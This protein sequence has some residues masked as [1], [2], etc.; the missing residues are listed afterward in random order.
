MAN[1]FEKQVKEAYIK[2]F[3]KMSISDSKDNSISVLQPSQTNSLPEEVTWK[4]IESYFKHNSMVQ[5]QIESYDEFINFGIQD[6]VNQEPPITE[7]NYT[8]KFGAISISPPQVLEEDRSL[9]GI[10]PMDARLR[11]L[12]YDAAI[13]CDIIETTR[14]P[15]DPTKTETKVL[16]KEVIGRIPVMLKSSICN[17][18]NLTED[19]LMEKGECPNDAGGYFIIKG[20]ERVLVGQLRSAYNQVDVIQQKSGNKYE[21]VA[22][23]RS[24]SEETGH[25]QFIKAMI[26]TNDRTIKFSLPFIK[27][28]IPVGIVFKSLGYTNEADIKD[29]LGLEGK[30]FEKYLNFIVRD[31][32][33][34]KT[35]D[36]AL[37]FIGQF[38]MHIIEENKE[39][40]YAWQ[41]VETELFPHLGITGTIK[42]QALFL[43]NIIRK[44]LQTKLGLR[45]GDGRDNYANKRVDIAG[46]LIYDIFRNLFKK[47]LNSIKAI[48]QKRKHRPDIQSTIS[49]LKHITKGLHQCFATG[50]WG[51]QKNASYI[52]TGVSQVLDRMTYYSTLS[53][54]RR[55]LIQTGKDSKNSA[56]R[57]LHQS[58]WGFVCPFECFDPLTK[59]LTWSGEPRYA[60]DIKVGDIL[61]DDEGE[62]TKVKSTCAGFSEMYT[63]EHSQPNFENYTVTS[64]HI[65][66]LKSNIHKKI[67]KSEDVFTVSIFDKSTISHTYT[68]FSTKKEAE[69]FIYNIL[70]DGTIDMAID[71]YLKVPEDTRIHLLSFK[72]KGVNWAKVHL[73]EDDSPYKAGFEFLKTGFQKIQEKYIITDEKNR[74][75]FLAGLLDA[76]SVLGSDIKVN[77]LERVISIKFLVESLGIPVL[78]EEATSSKK[79]KWYILHLLGNNR[80]FTMSSFKLVKKSISPFVGWQLDGNGRFLL[81]DFTVTHNTP[82]GQRV[83]VVLNLAITSKITRKI[84]VVD[85][86]KVIET[87][88]NIILPDDIK[89]S[90]IKYST[91]VYLNGIVMGFTQD[92]DSL[93]EEIRN[94]RRKKM[95]DREVSVTYDYT[96]NDIK[97]FCDEGRFTR[98]LLNL[99]DNDIKL[100]SDLLKESNKVK[101]SW[102]SLVKKN[103]IVY[104]DASELENSV[105][106]MTPLD[107]LKQE[108]E[109]CEIHPSVVMGVLSGKI[110]YSD[111]S[112][113]PRL[114]YSASMGKQALGMPILSHNLRTDTV[115]HVLQYPQKP[116]VLTKIAKFTGIEKMPSGINAIVAVASWGTNQEDSICINYS[117]VQRGLFCLTTYHTKSCS[118]KKR[119]AYSFEKVCMPPVNSD[120]IDI[121][122][123]GYFKRKNADYSL[124]DEHGIIRERAKNGG[125]IKVKKGVVLVGKVTSIGNKNGEEILEDSSL[126]VESGEEGHIDRVQVMIT[127]NGYKL[128]KVV[129]RVYRAPTLGDKLAATTGQK[130]TI[131]MIY[132]QEDMPF[133][134]SG[135]VPDLI[136]N[137]LCLPSRSAR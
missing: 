126:V 22:S 111:H 90:N 79:A 97:I 53:H 24:M 19:E 78:I 23:V 48:L 94:M 92:P 84:P 74:E 125:A 88:K 15:D 59:I 136:I 75:L 131:G 67:E 56:M 106:A 129:I 98:P 6:I 17:L 65:L 135:I 69:D 43:A 112:Q 114:C 109:Y 41:I 113:S 117:A 54:L 2:K 133:T 9:K 110:P 70:Y 61:V 64:N 85:V 46:A 93:L 128:V 66:T 39:R 100:S 132:R 72:C 8:V 40:D 50:N 12:N 34:C 14:D 52:K 71:D 122:K 25:S 118:E 45:Y 87:C 86:K 13:G 32:S 36:D 35:K 123:A 107:L 99:E 18:S 115:L 57:Q 38:K 73:D 137:S 76:N 60:K 96:D 29:I 116:I 21:Y 28:P 89:L 63:I 42:E 26:E 62:P 104:R 101:I 127:P 51:V 4:I 83:G 11:D 55:I 49:R 105:V 47:Y 7:G 33:F 16:F 119:D 20:N 80:D 1:L 102:P 27:E 10:Y 81:N 44:L 124:L 77:T 91:S 134:A 37:K 121:G 5:N 82:E 120:K 95:L 31:S 68:E 58:S 30:K 3:E 108:C 130:A 103:Y